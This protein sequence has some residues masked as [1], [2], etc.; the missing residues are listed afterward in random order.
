MEHPHYGTPKKGGI[1]NKGMNPYKHWN[2]HIYFDPPKKGVSESLH[3]EKH[4]H[5]KKGGIEMKLWI[6]WIMWITNG[7]ILQVPG[8]DKE[9]FT[10]L[11]LYKG[12]W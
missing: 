1:E 11:A 8:R 7:I 12:K 5:P 10:K 4:R 3:N 9:T 2:L 6:M